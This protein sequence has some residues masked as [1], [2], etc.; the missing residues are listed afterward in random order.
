MGRN[1]MLFIPVCLLFVNVRIFT[2][3]PLRILAL[4]SAFNLALRTAA[5]FCGFGK[6]GAGKVTLVTTLIEWK[7]VFP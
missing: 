3:A 6:G 2:S 7:G 5:V 4:S 1:V